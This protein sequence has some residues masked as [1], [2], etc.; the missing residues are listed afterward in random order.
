MILVFVMRLFVNVKMSNITLNLTI[1]DSL[2]LT[3]IHYL[4]SYP[5]AL[6]IFH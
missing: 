2:L 4:L 5:N 1:N 3:K 6:I